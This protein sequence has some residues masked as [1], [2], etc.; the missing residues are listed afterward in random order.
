MNDKQRE[1][2]SSALNRIGNDEETLVM[3]AEMAAEDAPQLLNKMDGQV[4]EQ[5]WSGYARTAHSLKGLLT[6]F[7][8]GDPVS[9]IQGL[10]NE[11]RAENGNAVSA[12]HTKAKPKLFALVREI[13]QLTDNA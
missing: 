9:E 12:A 4:A 5:Q 6:T 7:E 13:D 10:I 2:F 8:T 1:R 11:A 3:L